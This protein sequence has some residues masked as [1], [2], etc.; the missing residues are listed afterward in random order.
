[1]KLA[2]LGGGGFRVPLVYRALLTTPSAPPVDEIVL[3]DLDPQRLSA[4]T[5]VLRH[6]GAEHDRVPTIRATTDLGVAL[7]AADVVFSAIR[8]GGLSGRVADERVALDLGVL[9]QETTGPGGVAYGMRTVPVA[10]HIADV[11]ARRC[12]SAW[13]INFTNPAGM[14][15]E[16]MQSV[17]GDRVVGICDSPMVLARRAARALGITAGDV[18]V[19]YAGLN[20]LGW[21]QGLSSGGRDRLADL[22][23]DPEALRTMEEGQLFGVEWIQTLGVLPNEYLYYY[24]F[25]RDAIAAIARRPATR[26][27][28]LLMQQEAFYRRVTEEPGLALPIWDQVRL[29]RNTT[30]MEESRGDADERHPDDVDGGGYEGVAVALIAALLGGEPTQLI[31]NV[32]N[33]ATITDLPADAVVEVPCMVDRRGPRPMQ[34]TPLSG[35][36]L[37]LVQQVKAVE[38]LAIRAAQTGSPTLAVRALAAHPLVDSVT[39][40]RQLLDGYR[41]RIPALAAIFAGT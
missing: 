22:V 25:T 16:A 14:I 20:H 34:V 24:Y 1:M 36:M 17:L 27:E 38:R 30:Y 37:G 3:H 2:V 4:I 21:L 15:T 13:F 35:D 40:A 5:A 12:P 32:R 7:D 29:E 9:G 10:M 26:G 28:Y 41:V 23:S 11:V 19:D 18:A 33:R 8:T 6:I 31:L 39:T